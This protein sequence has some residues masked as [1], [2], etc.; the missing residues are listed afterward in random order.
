[1]PPNLTWYWG[2]KALD[3]LFAKTYRMIAFRRTPL[4]GSV[5]HR[6]KAFQ[7]LFVGCTLS[8]RHR[9]WTRLAGHQVIFASVLLRVVSKMSRIVTEDDKSSRAAVTI[10]PTNLQP[11]FPLHH[12]MSAHRFYCRPHDLPLVSSEGGLYHVPL[13]I[14]TVFR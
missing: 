7:A 12:T 3:S 1:M 10:G 11:I 8:D 6:L 2:K 13:H 4:E 5:V 9:F 14:Y